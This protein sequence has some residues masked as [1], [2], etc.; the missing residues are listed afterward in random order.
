MMLLAECSCLV[1]GNVGGT[2]GALLMSKGYEYRYIFNLGNY[3]D[4]E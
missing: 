3:G 2:H 4:E 1:A